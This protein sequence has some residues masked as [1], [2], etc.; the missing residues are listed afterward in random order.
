M[1]QEYDTFLYFDPLQVPIFPH[2]NFFLYPKW[3]WTIISIYRVIKPVH[4][5]IQAAVKK[6]SSIPDRPNTKAM[7][8]KPGFDKFLQTNKWVA[9]FSMKCWHV[10][11]VNIHF[12]HQNLLLGLGLNMIWLKE[13]ADSFFGLTGACSDILYGIIRMIKWLTFYCNCIK[14]WGENKSNRHLKTIF[15]VFLHSLFS[16]KKKKKGNW[17]TESYESIFFWS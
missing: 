3:E 2:L 13:L 1:R 9:L 8:L 7:W 6:I 11:S 10:W 12:Q 16:K 14:L 4:S 5:T 15:L 17:E